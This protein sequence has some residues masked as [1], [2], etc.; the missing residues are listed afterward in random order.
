M[1]Q[2]GNVLK[3][4]LPSHGPLRWHHTLYVQVSVKIQMRRRLDKR[5]LVCNVD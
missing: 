2:P 3:C 5:A 1:S 4:Y